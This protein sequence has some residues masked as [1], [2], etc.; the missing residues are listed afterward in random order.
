VIGSGGYRPSVT[1]N[2]NSTEHQELSK[3]LFLVGGSNVRAAI[4]FVSPVGFVLLFSLFPLTLSVI[5]VMVREN[6]SP[7]AA[8]NTFI[9]TLLTAAA[10]CLLLDKGGFKSLVGSILAISSFGS[11]GMAI[12]ALMQHRHRS[13][14]CVSAFDLDALFYWPTLLMLL[15]CI[16]GSRVLGEKCLGVGHVRVGCGWA[17]LAAMY[18]GMC[19]AG[20]YLSRPMIPVFCA[21]L[22][23]HWAMSFGMAVGHVL[24]SLIV[25]VRSR[26]LFDFS[27]RFNRSS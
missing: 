26:S 24:E 3:G 6:V 27:Y 17:S 25:N 14:C 9:P 4:R 7:F 11:L 18:V 2:L 1:T 21:S 12:G 19:L 13:S 20:R 15:F 23:E 22:G 8:A 5:L 16:V 10:Q